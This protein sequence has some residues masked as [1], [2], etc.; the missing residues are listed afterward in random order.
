MWQTPLI[1]SPENVKVQFYGFLT[2]SPTHNFNQQTPV[3]K[4]PARKHKNIHL[5]E[6]LPK[7]LAQFFQKDVIYL[8]NYLSN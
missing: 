2:N 5:G 6:L 7:T 1:F 3:T 4:N 8:G